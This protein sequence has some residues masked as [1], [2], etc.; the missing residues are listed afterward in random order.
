MK[1]RYF[2]RRIGLRRWRWKVMLHHRCAYQTPYEFLVFRHWPVR[3][4]FYTLQFPPMLK[5][6]PGPESSVLFSFP[7]IRACYMLKPFLRII[8]HARCIGYINVI[9][10]ITFEWVVTGIR[11][12]INQGWIGWWQQ[13]IN[14][15]LKERNVRIRR[16]SVLVKMSYK[17][18]A[19]YSYST[20]VQF[21]A[22]FF[23]SKN[24]EA[25]IVTQI[26]TIEKITKLFVNY[27]SSKQMDSKT[28]FFN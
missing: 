6:V 5:R 13:Y 10:G 20:L 19:Q 22:E 18:N 1:I 26:Q 16:C 23:L 2:R 4:I 8:Y 28:V 27:A 24:V 9:R 25:S 21:T 12:M 11:V 14:R 15:A 3:L 17:V 7:R